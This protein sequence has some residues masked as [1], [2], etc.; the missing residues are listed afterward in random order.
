[1]DALLDGV[2]SRE[3]LFCGSSCGADTMRM[4]ANTIGEVVLLAREK[5]LT[6]SLVGVAL[7]IYHGQCVHFPQAWARFRWSSSENGGGSFRRTEWSGLLLIAGG[8]VC[9][10]DFECRLLRRGSDDKG[11]GDMGSR[12]EALGGKTTTGHEWARYRGQRV[13]PCG[14]S[15]SLLPRAF[16]CWL[17]FICTRSPTGT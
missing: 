17:D 2:I 16:I 1:M 11:R 13:S 9:E 7:G 5:L 4:Y 15:Q 8:A 6:S 3:A 12:G 10:R 14:D